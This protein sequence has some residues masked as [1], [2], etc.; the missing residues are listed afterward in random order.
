MI[1]GRGF[2]CGTDDPKIYRPD[3]TLDLISAGFLPLVLYSICRECDA[4]FDPYG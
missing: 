3:R 2:A 1:V 4:S